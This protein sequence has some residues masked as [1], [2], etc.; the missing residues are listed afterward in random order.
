[1]TDRIVGIERCEREQRGQRV[2]RKMNGGVSDLFNDPNSKEAH[3]VSPN[4]AASS[5]GKVRGQGNFPVLA[6]NVNQ[7]ILKGISVKPRVATGRQA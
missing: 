4:A 2:E 6:T 3:L 5:V 1:M 7:T